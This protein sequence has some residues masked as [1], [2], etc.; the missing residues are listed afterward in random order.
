VQF[1][2]ASFLSSEGAE[3]QPCADRFD[4]M[5]VPARP[6]ASCTSSGYVAPAASRL[7]TVAFA[8]AFS[9]R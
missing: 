5:L 4:P 9:D 1:P 6:K 7:A 8:F 2:S 3:L